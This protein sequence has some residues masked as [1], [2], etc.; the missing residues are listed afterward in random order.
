MNSLPNLPQLSPVQYLQEVSEFPQ[1]TNQP[2]LHWLRAFFRGVVTK[3]I[4]LPGLHN[5]GLQRKSGRGTFK[6]PS[7]GGPGA[8]EGEGTSQ[9][10]PETCCEF[11]ST[12]LK[13]TQTPF[14]F[15]FH[16]RA[17]SKVVLHSGSSLAWSSTFL[18][19]LF[20]FERGKILS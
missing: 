14:S 5:I 11:A 3:C 12:D 16:R 4:R 1:V 15:S 2:T 10:G 6:S 20:K 9:C 18:Y 17:V 8:H 19:V 13:R 7:A